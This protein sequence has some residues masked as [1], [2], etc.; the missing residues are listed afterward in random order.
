MLAIDLISKSIVVANMNPGDS[1]PLIPGFLHITYVVNTNA[2]FG[3]GLGNALANRIVYIVVAV[4]ASA[5]IIYLYVKKFNKLNMFYKAMMMLILVGAIGNLIDRIFYTP[6]Y[7]KNSSV[8]VVDWIDFCGIWKFIFNWADS[9]IV[10]GVIALA[11]YLI[12]D[13]FRQNKKENEKI[14]LAKQTKEKSEV[15]ETK[16]LEVEESEVVENKTS[17]EDEKNK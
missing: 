5:V 8:G 4:I 3:L 7:L 17:Q 11:I 14:S 12:V 6:E 16:E 10:V 2:A 9:C 1:I 15:N 13:E